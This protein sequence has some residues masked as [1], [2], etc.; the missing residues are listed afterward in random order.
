MVPLPFFFIARR[1]CSLLAGW[2]SI[3]WQTYIQLAS[4]RAEES[5]PPASTEE[6][7]LEKS[8]DPTRR[9]ESLIILVWCWNQIHFRI[10]III[11]LIDHL[12]HLL[13]IVRLQSEGK[14]RTVLLVNLRCC[15]G[16]VYPKV[17][18]AA[19]AS[20]FVEVFVWLDWGMKKWN[21]SEDGALEKMSTI[22]FRDT[23]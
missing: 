15:I 7:A 2:L 22:S 23:R 19:N 9:L 1:I 13:L 17:D 20:I 6:P 3:S 16:I 4:A 8:V 10:I 21:G 12:F 11:F 18:I 5:S 14:D